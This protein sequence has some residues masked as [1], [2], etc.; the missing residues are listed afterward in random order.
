MWQIFVGLFCTVV[1]GAILFLITEKYLRPSLDGPIA[2]ID[3]PTT[4]TRQPSMPPSSPHPQQS[5]PPTTSSD[6]SAKQPPLLP[7]SPGPEQSTPRAT[8]AVTSVAAEPT[9]GDSITVQTEGRRAFA[10]PTTYIKSFIAEP[11]RIERGKFAV[12]GWV[13]DEAATRVSIDQGIGSV[14][15]NA[16]SI[17]WPRDTTTYTVSATGPLGS[18]S[19]S[20]TVE[21]VPSPDTSA[22]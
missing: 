18:Y 10:T 5:A 8:P 17:V 22:K 7:N 11:A 9:Y 13:V 1:G 16:V 15:S 19:T 20:V 3:S 14:R 6:N 12:L 21:V 4:E 2:V